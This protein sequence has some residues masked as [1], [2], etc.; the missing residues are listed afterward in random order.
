M[1]QVA[2]VTS[3]DTDELLQ[4]FRIA[5]FTTAENEV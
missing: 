1:L 4:E 3:R 5:V 2:E